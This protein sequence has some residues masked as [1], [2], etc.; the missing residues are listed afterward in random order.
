MDDPS[1]PPPTPPV[2]YSNPPVT[3]V[4]GNAFEAP[5]Y[6]MRNSH[7]PGQ[8]GSL[9]GPTGY[10]MGEIAMAGASVHAGQGV[11]QPL[12]Y[13]GASTQGPYSGMALS[14]EGL[15]PA[16]FALMNPQPNLYYPGTS[17]PLVE[18]GH[19][20][21]YP[22]SLPMGNPSVPNTALQNMT[23]SASV[24]LNSQTLPQSGL[25]HVNP[26]PLHNHQGPIAAPSNGALNPPQYASQGFSSI[27][28]G[29]EPVPLTTTAS[30]RILA[31]SDVS[32][33]NTSASSSYQPLSMPQSTL[34]PLSSST[35]PLPPESNMVSMEVPAKPTLSLSTSEAQ[36]S[37]VVLPPYDLCS[38]LPFMSFP[39]ITPCSDVIH[40]FGFP[41]ITLHDQAHQD[42]SIDTRIALPRDLDTAASP[43]LASILNQL[44]STLSNIR[45]RK[46]NLP[47]VPTQGNIRL[48]E[49]THS[50]FAAKILARCQKFSRDNH[51]NR[52]TSCPVQLHRKIMTYKDT[53]LVTAPPTMP[54]SPPPPADLSFNRTMSPPHPSQAQVEAQTRK[55]SPPILSSPKAVT[56][57]AGSMGMMDTH[58]V[59]PAPLQNSP[60]AAAP[61]RNSALEVIVS[62][63]HPTHSAITYPV[64]NLPGM[65]RRNL[66]DYLAALFHA[67]DA[68]DPN[69]LDQQG[70]QGNHMFTLDPQRNLTATVQPGV[71]K[72][73]QRLV[74][75][76]AQYQ[77]LGE[78]PVDD[79]VRL[80]KI[81]EL[82]VQESG[83]VNLKRL[84]E[85]RLTTLNPTGEG[86]DPT[87]L[88]AWESLEN[89][90][91]QV[92]NGVEA[93]VTI[94]MVLTGE[95]L[96]KQ[97]YSEELL[98]GCLKVVKQ[99]L[100]DF[101]FTQVELKDQEK[102]DVRQL[103]SRD[104]RV[105]SLFGG[106]VPGTLMFLERWAV[107][108]ERHD[109]SESVVITLGFIVIPAF[110]VDLAKTLGLLTANHLAALRL[111]S[112]HIL[113]TIFSRYPSQRPWI[114]EEVLTSLIKL[115]TGARNLRQYKLTDAKPIQ[116]VT[117]LVVQLIQSCSQVPLPSWV[118]HYA[119]AQ[120]LKEAEEGLNSPRSAIPVADINEQ[121]NHYKSIL[122]AASS[123]AGYVV[124]FLLSRCTKS[125]QANEGE[126]RA[127]LENF[128]DD[129]LSLLGLPEWPAAELILR[130]FTKHLM[131][132]V[133]DKKADNGL[134][135]LAIEY[136]GAVAARIKK[137]QPLFSTTGADDQGEA[138]R[139][140]G[141]AELSN[142][143]SG[144]LTD[145]ERE[146]LQLATSAMRCIPRGEIN[147]ST[148]VVTIHNL[149][150]N[151]KY[152]IE[153]LENSASRA[154]A[155]I[156]GAACFL[157]ADWSYAGLTGLNR[158]RTPVTQPNEY[159]D[160][161]H[162]E[163][164]PLVV[165]QLMERL[166]GWYQ[167]TLARLQSGSMNGLTTVAPPRGPGD[168]TD[169][170]RPLAQISLEI[171]ASRQSLY[172]SFDALLVRIL[173][174]LDMNV[175]AFRTKALKALGQ[176]INAY[177]ELLGQLNVKAGINQRLQDS[178]PAVRD[179]A[180]ELVSRYLTHR[181]ALIPQYYRPISDRVLDMGL[182]VRKR[183]IRVLRDIYMQISDRELQVDISD[184][185]LHRI[186]DEDNHVCQLAYKT[187]QDL[188]FGELVPLP[189]LAANGSDITLGSGHAQA[190]A[191]SDTQGMSGGPRDSLNPGTNGPTLQLDYSSL[192]ANQGAALLHR[193]HIIMGVIQKPTHG[194]AQADIVGDLLVHLVTKV[195]GAAE[196]DQLM[197]MYRLYVEA[198]MEH[199]LTLEERSADRAE[200]AQCMHLIYLF[201]KAQPRLFTEG[202]LMT[203]QPY[204]KD[205]NQASGDQ[206]LLQYVLMTIQQ[207][208][209]ELKH[210]NP[211]M[212]DQVEKEL[213]GILTKSPQLVLNVAVPCLCRV[214]SQRTR[215]FQFLTRILR[216]CHDGLTRDIR[217]HRAGKALSPA[218]KIM[219][220]LILLGL[221]CR[222]FDFDAKRE[223]FPE[224][225]PEL[226][227]FSKGQVSQR[228]FSS[229][230]YFTGE[231]LPRAIRLVSLQS[232]G[233]LFQ[234]YPTLMVHQDSRTLMNGIFEAEDVEMKLQLLKIFA[235]FLGYEQKKLADAEAEVVASA[236]TTPSKGGHAAQQANKKAT[237][238]V[239][240]KVL[241]GNAQELG[242]AGVASSIMQCYLD[243]IIQCVLL[244]SDPLKIVATDVIGSIISQGL[245][246]PLK[247]VP[248]LVALQTDPFVALR[249]KSTKLHHQLSGKFP[250][251]IHSQVIEAVK[252]AFEYQV[253]VKGDSAAPVC[254]YTLDHQE[255]KPRAL[256]DAFY[257][258][259][260][261]K[262]NRRTDFIHAVIKCFDLD[263][264]QCVNTSKVDLR[265][266]RFLAETLF[267]L[268]Y[269]LLDEVLYVNYSIQRL[270]AVAGTNLLHHFKHEF[271]STTR[272]S[273]LAV[274]KYSVG[275]AM[276]IK[277]RDTL[278][279]SYSIGE[280]RCQQYNPSD[281]GSV[282]DKYVTRQ[283]SAP[284]V[285][286][287]KDLPYVT[288]ELV[289]EHDL[290]VQRLTYCQ[291]MGD[292][293]TTSSSQSPTVGTQPMVL[294]STTTQT[295]LADKGDY[296]WV[297]PHPPL[298]SMG[299]S[300]INPGESLQSSI[301]VNYARGHGMSYMQTVSPQHQPPVAIVEIPQLSPHQSPSHGLSGQ[302][303]SGSPPYPR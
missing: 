35:A 67:E 27:A 297:N 18:T 183:A 52:H 1:K 53:V 184:R 209:P 261:E 238:T 84:V 121:Q 213:L 108:L 36:A 237:K 41:T 228:V 268:E 66:E 134:K 87:S 20:S 201:S 141:A 294:N 117:A 193:I 285:L 298:E 102:T 89:A 70:T 154:S 202:H 139:G 56:K 7:H 255:G 44:D 205:G 182:S 230:I 155:E 72:K 115:P 163:P 86:C 42:M 76:A 287:W 187:V 62:N 74:G 293:T 162:D 28:T 68:L 4:Q 292:E 283:P 125:K 281:F 60:S 170:G 165:K 12:G 280:A 54:Q 143:H 247:C 200:L 99:Q 51:P 109:V 149:W 26:P 194:T 274:A 233:Q 229:M 203:L 215:S 169:H 249:E 58:N 48:S 147:G 31:S 119:V 45:L 73:V 217:S 302:F 82:S 5:T 168:L 239:D 167:T 190:V 150:D 83:R 137:W 252:Q 81:L 140:D 30:Q 6:G 64:N 151:Q 98:N 264:K 79:L 222:Y 211:T 59:P 231:T 50:P 296:P 164:L 85:D 171:L 208:L 210:P 14:T 219:R 256:L 23:A 250:S 288:Q 180:I 188:W 43:Y 191:G 118:T 156:R 176:I 272:E 25:T 127:L 146:R 138:L 57:S 157:L 122:D 275:I 128:M 206:R 132:Y 263:Y 179:A 279:Q 159:P 116:M 269:K 227:A 224:K 223:E 161:V 153:Y 181:P 39:S 260:K 242:E 290:Q 245:A 199:L 195:D 131:G 95:N 145:Q 113:R 77:Q 291:L 2:Y 105:K 243:Q 13:G 273:Q 266:F 258:I 178:S 133:D 303:P 136:L 282:K 34:P 254:G 277:V 22:T 253:I 123:S 61:S 100:A 69:T 257:T 221:L 15:N 17:Y 104:A 80:L 236:T 226:H 91:H 196:R 234:A 124:K 235:E 262:R 248:I 78:I 299:N 142:S 126:Y 289:T 101:L 192:S 301:P 198:L 40:Q 295:S 33:D 112:L 160:E 267:A 241:I 16:T 284:M 166:C 106:L 300:I 8:Y 177:P 93:A 29:L 207:T 185:V 216:S 96:N 63:A 197:A 251:F 276:L 174:A 232:L 220:M 103:F 129:V 144:T 10:S 204:L 175:V 114:L 24:P 49:P 278:K 271:S 189:L 246:H 46:V 120:R 19:M 110:F 259:L 240:L 218:K 214:V 65:A 55:V 172:Q 158:E 244:K 9:P 11:L 152:L 90:V 270:L 212:L 3:A 173:A 32:L 75:K 107:L 97:L 37:E 286:G 38:A 148:D 92:I 47:P 265:W 186:H 225:F 71:L 21:G 130:I 88:G 94:L 111:S 135:G